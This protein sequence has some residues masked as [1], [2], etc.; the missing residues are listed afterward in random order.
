[1][2]RFV[3]MFSTSIA[4]AA[5]TCASSNAAPKNSP[6]L[7]TIYESAIYLDSEHLCETGMLESYKE[8][9]APLQRYVDRV[10]PMTERVDPETGHYS[11]EASGK[12]Y[13]IVGAAPVVVGMDPGVDCWAAATYAFF[14]SVNAQLDGR[15][16]KF[17]AINGGNDLAG[18]FLTDEQVSA[19]RASLKKKS[20]WPYI[21]TLDAPNFG[22]Y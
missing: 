1:M 5:V 9:A 2:A 22:M 10:A 14:D 20:D 17:Y 13:Q 21:P 19:M 3:R 18:V 8:L 12:F 15:E 4:I 7:E 16:V 6:D 11:V